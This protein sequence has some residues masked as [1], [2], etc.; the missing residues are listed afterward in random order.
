MMGP[1][2]RGSS[3][4]R[5]SRWCDKNSGSPGGNGSKAGGG[6][7]EDFLSL[8]YITGVISHE[9]IANLE[10]MGIHNLDQISQLTVAQLNELGLSIS[11][12]HELQLNALNMKKLRENI[13]K[14]GPKSDESELNES[15]SA[16]SLTHSKDMDMRIT[17]SHTS[18]QNDASEVPAL[19]EKDVDMRFLPMVNAAG[20][21]AS[22]SEEESLKMVSTSLNSLIKTPTVDYSQYLKDSNL[23]DDDDMDT[24]E[25][26]DN[27]LIAQDDED[28]DDDEENNLKISIEDDEQEEN[29]RDHLNSSFEWDKPIVENSTS[30][31]QPAVFDTKLVSRPAAT[32]KIDYTKPFGMYKPADEEYE[33]PSESCILDRYGS[34][35]EPPKKK[36]EA[37]PRKSMYANTGSMSE[38]PGA[39]SPSAYKQTNS[40][41]STPTIGWTPV[42]SSTTSSAPA[43]PA[44]P[45]VKPARSSIYDDPYSSDNSDDSDSKSKTSMYADR[46]KDMRLNFLSLDGKPGEDGSCISDV[47]LR[48]P[49]KPIMTN[50]IPATEIDASITSHAPIVYKVQEVEIPK[51]NYKDIR[52]NTPR[53]E[54]TKDPRLRRI[55]GMYN[56]DDSENSSRSDPLLPGLRSPRPAG[57]PVPGPMVPRLDPRTKR[58]QESKPPTHSMNSSSSA[59]TAN[60]SNPNNP[61]QLDVQTILQRSNWYTDLSSKHKIMVNQQLAI[62]STEMKK[63]HN[64]DKSTDKLADFMQLL[65]SNQM[66]QFILTNLNV[67]VDDSVT[68]CEVPLVPAKPPPLMC[69]P[70]PN[71]GMPP[72]GLLPPVNIP[73]PAPKPPSLFDLPRFNCPPEVRPGLLG[74]APNMPFEQF[75]AMGQNKNSNPPPL[76]EEWNDDYEWDDPPAGG[77]FTPNFEQRNTN[78][79]NNVRNNAMR[80]NNRIGNNFRNNNERWNNSGGGGG[81][82]SNRRNN[83]NHRRMDKKK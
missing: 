47:D 57:M 33:K 36:T 43:K 27:L 22:K 63:Y 31:P 38:T 62:L 69:V 44:A 20:Q 51:P 77:G 67:Y 24:T 2:D 21:D 79:F 46:D 49:F 66:L 50:Y 53:P 71:L 64:S 37:F 8:K 58:H 4:N 81:N 75:L 10:Q 40:P 26:A 45:P 60:A 48:L 23:N 68:F 52:R 6:L 14:H 28:D 41:N 42:S 83:N 70:P 12:I 72:I 15:A 34:D 55:F 56:E 59:N 65:A 32:Q 13:A 61:S 82:N 80:N 16:S 7:G 3:K 73:P 54:R 5:R 11:Q 35:S 39:N 1:N 25:N 9:Q 29:G 18:L 78:N 19:G 74:V 30:Q 76:L 17:P